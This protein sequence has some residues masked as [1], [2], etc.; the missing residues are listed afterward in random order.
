MGSPQTFGIAQN[1]PSLLRASPQSPQDR[2]RDRQ[3]SLGDL[4]WTYMCRDLAARPINPMHQPFHTLT[5]KLKPA[6]SYQSERRRQ[7]WSPR[8]HIMTQVVLDGEAGG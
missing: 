7:A 8:Y 1:R 6:V 3:S 2:A 4:H 5:N